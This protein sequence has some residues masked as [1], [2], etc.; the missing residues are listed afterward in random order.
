MREPLADIA[1]AALRLGRPPHDRAAV[2]R[3][4]PEPGAPLVA[5]VW[6]SGDLG[7]VLLLHRR[8]DG[9]LAEELYHSLRG[10]DGVWA[11]P[12][13]LG[14]GVVGAEIADPAVLRVVLAGAPMAVVAESESLIDT[15]D[16]DDGALA[17]VWEVL[18]GDEV[19][20]VEV[21]R[22]PPAASGTSTSSAGRLALVVLLPGE[23][24]RLHAL[25]R[26]D[27]RP[28]RLGDPLELRHPER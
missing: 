6:I 19:D 3:S 26:E 5:D 1:R 25:R 22:S 13:H 21:E 12:D 17:H 20:L 28:V 7:F 4:E 16:G 2:R 18:L 24:A 23:R 8:D 10:E 11:R 27:G 9:Q 14:G 15:P